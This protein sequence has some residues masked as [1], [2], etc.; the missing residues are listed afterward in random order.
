ME[1]AVS[2][3]TAVSQVMAARQK[4][5]SSYPQEVGISFEGGET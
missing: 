3:G 2:Q 4:G 1:K 5:R